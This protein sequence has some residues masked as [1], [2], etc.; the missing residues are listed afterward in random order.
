MATFKRNSKAEIDELADNCPGRMRPI[1][2]RDTLNLALLEGVEF[3]IDSEMPILRAVS[4]AKGHPVALLPFSVAMNPKGDNFD[5]FVHFY[6]DDCE[7]TR[8]WNRPE[9]YLPRLSKFSGVIMP[10][11]STCWDFPEP[12]KRWSAWRSQLLAAWMQK[13]GLTVIPNARHQP[14]CDFLIEGQ[15]HNSVIAICGRGVTKNRRERKLFLRDVRETVDRLEPTAIVYYGSEKY[16]AMDYPR[17]LGIPVWSYPGC[18]L[19]TAG[20]GR[21]GQR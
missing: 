12:L 7:F 18:G 11:F 4:P 6:E 13:N 3:T 19:G 5:C 20:G 8:L 1:H 16:G 21:S 14:G 2:R 10:D 9:A 15:P 17:K